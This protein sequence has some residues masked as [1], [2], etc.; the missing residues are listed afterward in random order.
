M[1]N[2]ETILQNAIEFGVCNPYTAK[3]LDW[4]I[5][6]K[7]IWVFLCNGKP[8]SKTPY[9]AI[10]IPPHYEHTLSGERIWRENEIVVFENTP[11]IRNLED[12]SEW[13][14]AP[15]MHEIAPLLPDVVHAKDMG[16]LN[17]PYYFFSKSYFIGYGS[18]DFISSEVQNRHYAQAYAELYIKLRD[19]GLLKKEGCD[20]K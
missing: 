5:P 1:T 10:K 8:E 3:L 2:N 11:N 9:L 7:Y 16:N 20:G 15:Q 17:Y 12:L 13:C 19:A 6:T 14:Y 18:K 4:K